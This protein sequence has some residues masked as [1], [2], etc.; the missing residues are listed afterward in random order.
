[1]LL[2][3]IRAVSGSKFF[4]AFQQDSAP[5]YHAKDPVA[6]LNQETPDFIPHALWPPNSPD[7]NLVNF[8]QC[9]VCFRSRSESIVPI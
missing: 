8:T 5:S 1:M 2:H 9:G 4:F 6:L 7:L 3:D